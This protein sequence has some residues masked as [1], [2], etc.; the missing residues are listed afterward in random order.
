MHGDR[1]F[2]E[3]CNDGSEK[4][5]YRGFKPMSVSPVEAHM[6]AADKNAAVDKNA[7]QLDTAEKVL[8]NVYELLELYAPAWY[9]EKLRSQ[10]QS[11]LHCSSDIGKLPAQ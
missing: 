3:N 9:S 2:N 10:I 6:N 5:S 1:S 8:A 4:Q 7:A 11:V